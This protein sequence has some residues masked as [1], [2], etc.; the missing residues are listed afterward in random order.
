M[1]I[2]LECIELSNQID[3]YQVIKSLEHNYEIVYQELTEF[4]KPTI[5]QQTNKLIEKGDEIC[6]Y[7]RWGVVGEGRIG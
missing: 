3:N 4:C 5:L 7:Q 1:V 6:G 2:N